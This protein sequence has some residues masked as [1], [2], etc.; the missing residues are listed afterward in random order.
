[1]F[2]TISLFLC[3]LLLIPVL[4]VRGQVKSESLNWEALL[5]GE[6]RVE[7]IRDDQGL[8]GIRAMFTLPGTREE[9]WGMLTDY[10]NFNKI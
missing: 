7:K 6:I 4:M 10:E 9:L 8:P 1:M 5:S 2:G 3:S